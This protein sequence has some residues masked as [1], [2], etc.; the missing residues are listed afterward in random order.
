[1]NMTYWDKTK[2]IQMPDSNNFNLQARIND[3]VL[4]NNRPEDT[5]QSNDFLIIR[6][7]WKF[8]QQGLSQEGIS[9]FDQRVDNSKLFD[10]S[11]GQEHTLKISP[12]HPTY[13]SHCSNSHFNK[14]KNPISKNE[15]V[16]TI[17]SK[18]KGK[19]KFSFTT[20][21][22]QKKAIQKSGNNKD[23]EKALYR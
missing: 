15:G 22:W 10:I 18:L 20:Q 9:T 4:R 1:M 14:Y 11:R 13:Y 12:D 6:K 21:N 19:H 23:I 3:L 2:R 8:R 5:F 17:F 16:K 7:S